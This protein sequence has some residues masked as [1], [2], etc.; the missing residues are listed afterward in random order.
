MSWRR[1]NICTNRRFT[2]D[3]QNNGVP[4]PV[5]GGGEGR[6]KI[7]LPFWDFYLLIYNVSELLPCLPKM[8]FTTE[9]LICSQKAEKDNPK[10]SSPQDNIQLPSEW[11][12]AKEVA[13]FPEYFL[14]DLNVTSFSYITESCPGFLVSPAS[15]LSDN[16][17]RDCTWTPHFSVLH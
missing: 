5:T 1:A 12:T 15:D 11:R 7:D 10:F 6:E 3:S 16:S 13:Q 8:P 4:G 2:A 14:I 9:C 17:S